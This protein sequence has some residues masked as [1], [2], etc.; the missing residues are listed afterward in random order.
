M[1]QPAYFVFQA[2]INDVE[3]MKPYQQRVH[4]TLQAYRGTVVVAGGAVE[5]REGAAP[6]GKIFIVR[7]DS[8]ADARAWYDSPDYQAIIGYRLAAAEC[9]AFLLEGVAL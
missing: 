3:G 2:T 1:S 5:S 7:F 6:Q 9:I 4:G 8:M